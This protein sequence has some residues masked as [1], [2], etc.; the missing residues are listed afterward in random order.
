MTK[1]IKYEVISGQVRWKSDGSVLNESFFKLNTWLY[2]QWN[3]N[4]DIY[5]ILGMKSSK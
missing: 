3:M 1:Y 4:I 2:L 5:A